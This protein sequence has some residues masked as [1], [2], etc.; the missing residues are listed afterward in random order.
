MSIPSEKYHCG[1]CTLNLERV[2]KITGVPTVS[3][4]I[5]CWNVYSNFEDRGFVVEG[6]R[7]QV[8]KLDEAI[9]EGVRMGQEAK[10]GV[11]PNEL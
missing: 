10:K 8:E 3:R 6:L 2:C 11:L 5:A 1:N 9:Q 4:D 7:P